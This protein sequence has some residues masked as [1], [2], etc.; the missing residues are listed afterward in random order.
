MHRTQFLNSVFELEANFKI[1][2]E[3]PKKNSVDIF[4]FASSYQNDGL[5]MSY[6]AHNP[7][8]DKHSRLECVNPLHMHIETGSK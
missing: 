6:Q 1:M 4:L 7:P 3:N 5:T 8:T 2:S